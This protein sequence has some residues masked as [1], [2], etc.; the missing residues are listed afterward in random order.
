M[1]EA[2]K[3]AQAIRKELKANFPQIKFTVRSENFAGGDAVRISYQN[4]VPTEQIHSI[5]DKY[6]Y[7][8]FDGMQDLYETTNRREDIPQAK[9]VQV[10]RSISA[11]VREAI[12]NDIA[13]RFGIENPADEA[14]W[15]RVFRS[16][17]NQVVWKE[18]SAMTF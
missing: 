3:V 12:K 4:G 5:T 11:D 15:Q 14:E 10:Q 18:S 9:Y 7:G 13:Q 2:A 8:S 17:S 1:T 6:Q 16:W